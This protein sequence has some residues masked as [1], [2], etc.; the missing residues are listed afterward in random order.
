[1]PRSLA[2]GTRG[3]LECCIDNLRFTE[4]SWH[5]KPELVWPRSYTLEGLVRAVV[6]CDAWLALQQPEAASRARRLR[7]VGKISS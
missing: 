1:M 4:S 5:R 3:A 2:N 6:L 7:S